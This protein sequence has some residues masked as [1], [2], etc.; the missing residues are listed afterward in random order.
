MQAKKHKKF[1]WE[2]YLKGCE[3]RLHYSNENYEILQDEQD[4]GNEEIDFRMKNLLSWHNILSN[5]QIA[6]DIEKKKEPIKEKSFVD[7]SALFTFPHQTNGNH[8]TETQ[9]VGHVIAERHWKSTFDFSE[10]VNN[11]RLKRGIVWQILR[12]ISQFSL[13]LYI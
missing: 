13:K 6:A 2:L 8:I 10:M 11:Y 7:E 12:F 1:S 5:R 4:V 9:T 3:I